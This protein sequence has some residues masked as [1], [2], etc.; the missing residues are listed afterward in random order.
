[1]WYHQKQY[2]QKIQG[3]SF[4]GWHSNIFRGTKLVHIHSH[5]YGN[6]WENLFGNN[7][8]FLICNNFFKKTSYL[9]NINITEG[10]INFEMSKHFS[11]YRTKHHEAWWTKKSLS[12]SQNLPPVQTWPNSLGRGFILINIPIL[13]LFSALP[14][15]CS[16]TATQTPKVWA[17]N[18]KVFQ[19]NC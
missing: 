3:A 6:L 11:W 12:I 1:M 8:K 7:S 4:R 5:F 10:I 14:F 2:H 15:C 9:G 13:C 17:C 19:M 18:T 16:R